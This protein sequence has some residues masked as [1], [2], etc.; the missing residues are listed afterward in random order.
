MPSFEESQAGGHRQIKCQGRRRRS[1]GAHTGPREFVHW[2]FPT[3]R[4]N[5][6]KIDGH[7]GLNVGEE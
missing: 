4:H 1:P 7:D 3:Q 6:S 2:G 5:G